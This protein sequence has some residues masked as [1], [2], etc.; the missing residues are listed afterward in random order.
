SWAAPVDLTG[1]GR[2]DAAVWVLEDLTVL[3]R[4]EAARRETEARLRAVIGTMAE[5]LIVQNHAGKVIE[6]NPASCPILG[7]SPE[8]L[9]ERPSLGPPEGCLREDGTPLPYDQHPDRLCQRTGQRVQDMILG[10]P[11]PEARSEDRSESERNPR[12]SLLAPR[13]PVR[14]LLV[15]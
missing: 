4:A 5:G 10:I 8:Q 9:L 2:P 6:C 12:S 15:N 7:C 3:R 13:S 11:I 1:H 14:W